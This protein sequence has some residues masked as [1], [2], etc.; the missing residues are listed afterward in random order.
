MK[1]LIPSELRIGNY[2]I[3]N[4]GGNFKDKE[5]TVTGINLE[6]ISFISYI[7]DN[8]YSDKF[9]ALYCYLKGIP[10]TEEWFLK[11]GFEKHVNKSAYDVR[12]VKD[13]VAIYRNYDGKYLFIYD[14]DHND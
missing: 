3:I 2:I 4:I 7:T 5:V 10:L 11:F 12:Y 8:L 14:F 1:T 13:K 9:K 6:K